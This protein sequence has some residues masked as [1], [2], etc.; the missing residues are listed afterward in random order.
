[1][2]GIEQLDQRIAIKYHL[3]PFNL[4]ETERYIVYRQ[5]KAGGKDNVFTDEAIDRIFKHTGGVPRKIN[6]LCDLS[7]LVASSTKQNNINKKI[8]ENIISDGALF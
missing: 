7:L 8:V 6:N 5:E 3:T 1:M 4:D 2:K